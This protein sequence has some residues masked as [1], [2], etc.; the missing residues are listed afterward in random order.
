LLERTSLEAIIN[1]SRTVTDRL[2]FLKGLEAIIF[3]EPTRSH[4]LERK[5]LHRIVARETWLFGEQYHLSVDDESLTAVLRKHLEFLGDEICIDHPVTRDDGSTGIIDLMLSRKI[6]VSTGKFE[7]LVVELKRPTVQIDAGV[8]DQVD[9]YANAIAND[10]RF[11][12]TNTKWVF[13]AVSNDI[14]SRTLAKDKGGGLIY[15][16]DPRF[17]VWMKPW[18]SIIAECR[19]RLEFFKKQLA[20]NASIDSGIAY[21]QRMH[22]EYIPARPLGEIL[23][24]QAEDASDIIL[25]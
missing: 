21:L 5:Q 17:T 20:Y 18:G 23:S 3:D 7:H 6:Q 8:L 11:K 22:A 12:H 9:R 25:T 10:E 16:Y 14:E 15:E 4:L 19:A 13:W 2:D 1:A 24:E